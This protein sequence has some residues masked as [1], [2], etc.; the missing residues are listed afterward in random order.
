MR[1]CDLIL[2]MESVDEV[3]MGGRIVGVI[4]GVGQRGTGTKVDSL[5]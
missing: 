4:K 1:G 3:D 2:E 5:A